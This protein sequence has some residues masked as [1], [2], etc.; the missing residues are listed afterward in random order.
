[1][2]C[3][4]QTSQQPQQ[5]TTVLPQNL[6][7]TQADWSRFLQRMNELLGSINNAQYATGINAV[8]TQYA[9]YDGT[10]LPPLRVTGAT[11]SFDTTHEQFGAGSLKLT[12][13]ASTITVELASSGYPITLHPNWKWIASLFLLTSATNIAGKLSMVTPAKQ[14]DVDISGTPGMS[15][16]RLYG[17]YDLTADA[18]T[19][20]T[21]LLT[22]TGVTVGQI[23]NLEG[24]ML[25]PSQGAVLPSPF[26]MTSGP[27]TWTQVV[28][29]GA[30]P[31][32]NANYVAGV[33]NSYIT[34]LSFASGLQ[35]VNIVSALP[36]LPNGSYPDGAL[37]VLTT[38]HK[39]YRNSAN[40]WTKAVDGADIVANSI[41][42]GSISVGAI[43]AS[44]IAA[45]AV[46]ANA[47]AAGAVQA[48]AISVSTLSAI[49]ANLGTITAGTLQDSGGKFVVNLAGQTQTIKDS[50]N[51]T[52][53]L[54]GNLG[55]D[56]GIQV[57]NASGAKIFDASS[58]AWD[59]TNN[60]SVLTTANTANTTANTANTTAKNLNLINL[61]CAQGMYGWTAAGDAA[62][63][64]GETG[65]NGPNGG[66]STYI[67]H[68]VS[69]V[70]SS[71]NN[72]LVP[73][74]PG[75]V[76][77]A[78]GQCRGVGTPN[79]AAAIYIA[80][81]DINKN[82]IG[83]TQESQNVTGNGQFQ[84]QMTAIAPSNAAFAT[85]GPTC[86]YASGTP[87]G[88]YSFANLWWNYQ[89][90]SVDEVPDGAS[91]LRSPLIG[92]AIAIPNASFSQ[93]VDASG[94]I[95]G[96][97]LT[98]GGAGAAWELNT[99]HGGNAELRSQAGAGYAIATCAKKF[100]VKP[101][102]S[103]WLGVWMSTPSGNYTLAQAQWYNASGTAIGT[104][105]QPSTLSGTMALC[106][107]SG[108]APANAAY[109]TLDFAVSEP[110]SGFAYGDILNIEC[111]V[112]DVRVAG[113]GAKA[114][115][116][117][118]DNTA[119]G[120][121]NKN[122]DNV[123]DT[124]TYGRVSTSDLSSNRVGLRVPGSGQQVGDQRNLLQ[125]TIT[126]Y[127][128]KVSPGVS[129]SASAGTPATATISVA[130]F[131]A[132]LGS[133]SVSYNAAS[134]SVTGTNGTNV[135]YYLY[136]NDPTYSGG[137]KTLVATTNQNDLYSGD[138][139]VYV[140]YVTVAFPS[141]GSGSGGGTGCPLRTA[142][143]IRRGRHGRPQFVRAGKVRVGDWLL[144]TDG[145]WAEVTFS[146]AELQPC[147][148]LVAEGFGTLGCS[149]SA[150]MQ[151]RDGSALSIACLA[152]EV[153]VSRAGACGHAVVTDLH[154][155]GDQWVQHITLANAPDDFFWTGDAK[156]AL[157]GHHNAKPP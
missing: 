141:S 97:S 25:E 44:A 153:V 124:A 69:G 30:K 88:Y 105:V 68:K 76:I 6:P 77:K 95:P 135:N 20:C 19:S 110:S 4:T 8:P 146:R 31:D 115:V 15:W 43:N 101:G 89:P 109:F 143:V 74:Y 73:V 32:N 130:A 103:V 79:G 78:T 42:A 60:Q 48:S 35:P 100:S 127:P 119:G 122:L 21:L 65:T 129:Y 117:F 98:A 92:S 14:Y 136:F 149:V 47:I 56:Y 104:A 5:P 99:A 106:S 147:V 152:R 87:Q 22:L 128:S 121:L 57:F 154:D 37:I 23:F 137:T 64:Y 45:G 26:I 1:M 67:V 140:G 71:L 3:Q 83:G 62:N 61:S 2:P 112:N 138:G 111:R 118:S 96:W 18:S 126:N 82:G 55:S 84:L 151:L 28:N 145:E 139:Y 12:A 86:G 24:W 116:D 80:F 134:A 113:S 9:V 54:I 7:Q 34:E 39:L 75:Q 40:V 27:R 90:S 52:R 10:G 16:A 13:T 125:R 36:T 72:T 58:G 133:V 66:T 156:D 142:W 93:P 63:W 148:R 33:V 51:T 81:W 91:Y 157:F 41:T 120:H 50:L 17:D 38:D 11:S 132:L 70:S 29:D 114:Y 123:S 102:D 108:V 53:V 49:S 46:T 144:R 107:A 85:M 150:P 131:T 94:N 59:A 155:L